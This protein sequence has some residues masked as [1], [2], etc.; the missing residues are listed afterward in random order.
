MQRLLTPMVFLSLLLSGAIFGFFYAWVCSTMWGLDTLEPNVAIAAM[1]EMNISVRNRVFMPAFFGTPVVLIATS[2][3]AYLAGQRKVAML[4]GAAGL[5]HL[6]CIHPH[7]K[8][9]RSDEHRA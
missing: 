9:Q 7:S 2:V 1:N 4:I 8:R 6:W 3:V 5:L